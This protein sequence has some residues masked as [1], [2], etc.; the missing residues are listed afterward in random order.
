MME[1][2]YEEEKQTHLS[3]LKHSC[4]KEDDLEVHLQLSSILM[5]HIFWFVNPPEKTPPQ[6]KR[7]TISRLI[8]FL[9][10]V[11]RHFCWLSRNFS[12]RPANSKKR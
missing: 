7:H 6:K 10:I 12:A 8:R 9:F 1:G 2:S 3:S 11:V 5:V 4:T